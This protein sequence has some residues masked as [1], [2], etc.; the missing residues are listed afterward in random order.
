[1]TPEHKALCERLRAN[2]ARVYHSMALRRDA[3]AAIESLSAELDSARKDAEDAQLALWEI[4]GLMSRI[5]K[6]N[7]GGNSSDAN[8]VERAR[9]IASLHC[10]AAIAR[11]QGSEH[12]K[13]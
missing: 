1:M 11:E 8:D 13:D 9:D 12:A 4:H 3:A 7:Q 6:R 5:L 2:S 10:S